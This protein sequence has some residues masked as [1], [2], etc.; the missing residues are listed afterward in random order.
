MHLHTI[1][2]KWIAIKEDKIE[3]SDT[4]HESNENVTS[5]NVS[6]QLFTHS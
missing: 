3:R 4:V 6:T 1:R 5:P 2:G